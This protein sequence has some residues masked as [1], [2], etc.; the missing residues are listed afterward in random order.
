M[1]VP[2]F[3]RK[4]ANI[5]EPVLDYHMRYDVVHRLI[6]VCD[7][8]REVFTRLLNDKYRLVKALFKALFD[9]LRSACGLYAV[10]KYYSTVKSRR[11]HKRKD[12]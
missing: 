8:I 3:A 2:L 1:L 7:D 5:L 10:F 9:P 6:A 4:E 11:L 12:V